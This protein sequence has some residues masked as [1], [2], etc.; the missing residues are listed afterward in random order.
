MPVS[1]AEP[2]VGPRRGPIQG[3]AEFAAGSSRAITGFPAL[4]RFAPRPLLLDL[5][6]QIFTHL[7]E[8]MIKVALVGGCHEVRP[9]RWPGLQ[10][11][12]LVG[13]SVSFSDSSRSTW[14]CSHPA[15]WGAS[16]ITTN[17]RLSVP[18]LTMAIDIG[19][20]PGTRFRSS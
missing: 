18:P 20:P 9:S 8:G 7:R 16:A 14:S 17:R 11:E 13:L 1:Y 19:G 10:G 15:R 2:R 12:L 3:A 5:A 6:D 4:A